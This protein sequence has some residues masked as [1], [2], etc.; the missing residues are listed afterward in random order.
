MPD[1][2]GSSSARPS[3][4]ADSGFGGLAKYKGAELRKILGDAGVSCESSHFGIKEL[5]DN[6][7]D[8]IAWAKDV[9][10]TQMMVPS[11]DGP[12]NPTMDDV[13]RAADEYNKMAEQ[14]AKAGIQQGLH[15]ET[16][17]LS[18][19]NGQRTYDILLELLDP[20]LVK[21]QFQCLHDQPGLRCRR[22]LHEV[23]GPLHFH[24]RAG[25]VAGDEEDDGR[26]SGLARLEEDLHRGQDRRHQELLRRDEPG[27]D[28]GERPV[29][30]RAECVSTGSGIRY[31]G[32]EFQPSDSASRT[33]HTAF[34]IPLAWYSRIPHPG[35]DAVD[36]HRKRAAQLHQVGGGLL[37]RRVVGR[38]DLV[39]H[40]QAPQQFDLQQVDRI[41]IRIAH[42]D[43]SPEH[44]VVLEQAGRWPLT[45][46][47][48]STACCSLARRLAPKPCRSGGTSCRS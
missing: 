31:A 35:R 6:L 16:F 44:R 9:G 41:D 42:V 19:V 36:R 47:T 12:K 46:S 14:S 38:R 25:L 39:Q 18:Q 7:P 1:F 34:R 22:V 5:R 37:V 11:L 30:E 10:L 21:F 3:G 13:K 28:E 2:S 29:P 26:G 48:P 33:P 43:R 23:S 8:R 40:G 45:S 17:E 27:L 24:A 20:K 32:S 15:N 4:Y